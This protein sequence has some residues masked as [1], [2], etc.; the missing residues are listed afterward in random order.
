MTEFIMEK[1]DR[2]AEELAYFGINLSM[3]KALTAARDG[4]LARE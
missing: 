1:A 4:D 2:L 3:D